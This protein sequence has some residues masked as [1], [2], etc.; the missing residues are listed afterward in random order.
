MSVINK[1]LRDLDERG[2]LGPRNLEEGI[3]DL[4]RVPASVEKRPWGRWSAGLV[5]GILAAGVGWYLLQPRAP[6]SVASQKPAVAPVATATPA[7]AP[8]AAPAPPPAEQMAANTATPAVMPPPVEAQVTAA[9]PPAVESPK[10]Q[11]TLPAQ[12][13][14]VESPKAQS[15]SPARP[16]AVESPK[17]QAA[18]PVKTPEVPAARVE[19]AAATPAA[20]ANAA[21]LGAASMVAEA[22]SSVAAARKAEITT[23]AQ[24]PAIQ[25]PERAPAPAKVALAES[26]AAKSA[27]AASP[28]PA[29]PAPTPAPTASA[30]PRIEAPTQVSIERTNR[31]LTG[32]PRAAA[33]YRNANDLLSQGRTDAAIARYGD[34]LQSDPRHVPARQ[35]L[36]VLTLEQ[37]RA[38]DA[39]NLLREGIAL[40][41][42]NTAWPILLAR[43][44]IQG[45][46]T[47]GALE[48]LERS[49]PQAQGQGQ[50]EYLAFFATLLQMH[51]R[52][53]E[54]IAQYEASL[55]LAPNSGRAMAGLAISLE[56]EQRIPEAREAYRK[57]MA[58]S[59][60]GRDLEAFVE[61]KVK[62]LQ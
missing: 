12:P 34:A 57:A 22:K 59:G 21:P 49:L 13:P 24:I 10:A 55:K 3:R 32:T 19:L 17:A 44:Q 58:A 40:V 39:Q 51:F 41:P 11:A 8:A 30:P 25:K 56:Q 37:G 7:K 6:Q 35:S 33:E 29:T 53:R 38:A 50:A 36:V 9:Q 48:T 60:L 54:A 28:I 14:A 31:G 26:P 15:T 43:L 42:E 20:A 52:H 4:E 45:G 47:K 61:R 18:A 2:G 46:D 62:Q 23:A 16:P 5:I 27:P 1:M